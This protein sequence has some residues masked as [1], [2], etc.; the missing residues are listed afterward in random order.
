MKKRFLKVRLFAGD[1][2]AIMSMSSMTSIAFAAEAEP[3]AQV[4]TIDESEKQVFPTE[5]ADIFDDASVESDTAEATDIEFT[6]EPS[7]ITPEDAAN[8]ET[9]ADENNATNASDFF[10]DLNKALK[11]QQENP[12]VFIPEDKILSDD[13]PMIVAADTIHALI[14]K[15]EKDN[16]VKCTDTF[17]KEEL[18]DGAC[19]RTYKRETGEVVVRTYKA[20]GTFVETVTTPGFVI[21]PPVISKL[22][23]TSVK[24]E[25][26]EDKEIPDRLVSVRTYN[27]DGTWTDTNYEYGVEKTTTNYSADEMAKIIKSENKTLN[28]LKE[29]KRIEESATLDEVLTF[30]SSLNT[31][32]TGITAKH[33]DSTDST[34]AVVADE[35][36]G[37]VPEIIKKAYSFVLDKAIAKMPGSSLIGGT[38]KDLLMKAM[39]LDSPA[40]KDPIMEKL[41][42]NQ[43]KTEQLLASNKRCEAI[44]NAISVCGQSLDAFSSSCSSLA[45]E[46]YGEKEKYKNGS[47]SETSMLINIAKKIGTPDQWYNSSASIFTRLNDAAGV[48]GSM[49]DKGTN[50]DVNRRNLYQLFYDYNKETSMFSGEAIDKSAGQIQSRIKDFALNCNVL[51]EILNVHEKVANFT[52]E[53]IEALTNEEEKA[54]C[55]KIKANKNEIEA[56]KKLVTYA[57]IG[58]KN[59]DIEM[60]KYGIVDA[61]KQ[62]SSQ[63]RTVFVEQ[64]NTGF[65][66][67]KLS[68]K[69]Y[70]QKSE[71]TNEKTLKS[72][73]A[74]TVE[75]IN[76]LQQH[77]NGMGITMEEYLD[78]IG[79]DLSPIKNTDRK[80]FL[81]TLKTQK[82]SSH[83]GRG[84]GHGFV[85]RTYNGINM[86]EKNA[87]ETCESS[88]YSYN[89]YFWEKDIDE[90]YRDG[91]LVVLQRAK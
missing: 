85:S 31:D 43:Y 34:E 15:M 8:E 42:Q 90:T 79:F 49:S 81:S 82:A 45:K 22:D 1:L 21:H 63:D 74:L 33:A 89:G 54:F 25:G 30:F 48:L 2:A 66:E 46:Y 71:K 18:V 64:T 56:K 69:I 16:P 72:H 19:V 3:T 40:K 24:A 55:K 51:M 7:L 67:I 5:I 27:A 76:K 36:P 39:H 83:S 37:E 23:G 78:Q 61:V 6:Q 10:D 73:S 26:F 57:F 4:V 35:K 52:D 88:Y 50:S 68:T 14:E 28:E 84:K 65:N 9:G 60:A 75:Q 58:N 62:Y 41:N 17:V 11:E 77:V 53:E 47:E 29:A 12:Q 80:A 91:I 20:D 44:V 13:N 87:K 70:T 32:G 86:K 38:V 59:S